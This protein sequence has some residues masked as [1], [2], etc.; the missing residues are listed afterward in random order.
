MVRYQMVR[1]QMKGGSG[2]AAFYKLS[3]GDTAKD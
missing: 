1:Y 3:R 2:F